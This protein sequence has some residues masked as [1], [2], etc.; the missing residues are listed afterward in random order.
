MASLKRLPLLMVLVILFSLPGIAQFNYGDFSKQQIFFDD[1][2]MIANDWSVGSFNNGCRFSAISNGQF[3]IRSFC[4]G[5]NP[6]FWTNLIFI[7]QARD[8]EIETSIQ[9][10]TGEDNN[11]LALVWGMDSN[12][13]FRFRF[14]ISGD[15]HYIID[16]FAGSWYNSRNWTPSPQVVRNQF[17]KLTVRKIGFNYYYY[18]N[19]NLVHTAPYEPFFGQ[20]IGFQGNQNTEMRVDYLKVSYL[21]R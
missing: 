15:G 9:Y 5:E 2:N 16:K 14:G 21:T 3:T 4:G 19:Q 20:Q 6:L 10:V 7:D 8:F 1:Y 12:N 17:S 18:I 13:F 11:A